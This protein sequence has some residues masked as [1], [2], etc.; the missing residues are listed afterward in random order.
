M[1]TTSTS[2]KAVIGTRRKKRKKNP[3]LE[4][5]RAFKALE[6]KWN[7]IVAQAKVHRKKSK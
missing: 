6:R 2:L 1:I 3:G 7:R 5:L 4:N